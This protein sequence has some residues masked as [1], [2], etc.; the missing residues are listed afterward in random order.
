[1][2]KAFNIDEKTGEFY[3]PGVRMEEG[4]SVLQLQY[5]QEQP[6]LCACMRKNPENWR[7]RSRFRKRIHREV[8]AP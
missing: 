1:M 6:L 7:Q 2:K 3:E 4:E 8:F 5:R